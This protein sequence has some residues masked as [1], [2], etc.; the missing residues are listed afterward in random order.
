M[1]EA[2]GLAK[3]KA[4]QSVLD[5]PFLIGSWK[6]EIRNSKSEI[7]PSSFEM[8]PTARFKI[9]DARTL[10]NFYAVRRLFNLADASD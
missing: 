7:H 10:R 4:L 6:F 9:P 3:Q 5:S 8:V 2:L 1:F